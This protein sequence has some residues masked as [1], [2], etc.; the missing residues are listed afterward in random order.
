MEPFEDGSLGT[1]ESPCGQ[2]TTSVGPQAVQPFY[3]AKSSQE[4]VEEVRVEGPAADSANAYITDD[5]EE[6]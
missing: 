6:Q 1:G 5:E 3:R 2:S 4:S